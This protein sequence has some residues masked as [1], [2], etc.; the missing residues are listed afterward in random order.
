MINKNKYHADEGPAVGII[1]ERF[2]EKKERKHA[3]DQ[4]KNKIQ[5]N[6]ISTTLSTKF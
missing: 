5:E 4:E 2:K 1:K 6:K 3:F